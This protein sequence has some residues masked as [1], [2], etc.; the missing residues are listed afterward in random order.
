M[1]FGKKR[2]AEPMWGDTGN[3]FCERAEMGMVL[4]MLIE[5]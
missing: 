2:A 4:K 5:E 3:V 1:H